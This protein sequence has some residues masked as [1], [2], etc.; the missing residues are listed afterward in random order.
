MID[1]YLYNMIAYIASTCADLLRDL[2]LKV[3]TLLSMILYSLAI[4]ILI[5]IATFLIT[6]D[7]YR[8]KEKVRSFLPNRST[9]TLQNIVGYLE[10]SLFG[11][12][13]AQFI[14]IFIN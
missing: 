5:L 12:Y 2:L 4:V 9:H 1:E 13:K 3:P 7:W 8:L 6:N 14:F 11:F 10:K